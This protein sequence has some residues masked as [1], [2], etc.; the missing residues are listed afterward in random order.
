[1]QQQTLT[2][3]L[4]A[5][6]PERQRQAILKSLTDEEK[7]FLR[8]SWSF[9][10]RENQ[11]APGG[12][13]LTWLILAGRG[14]G[15]TRAGAEWIRGM[16]CGDTPLA[17]GKA[18]RVALVAETAADARDVMVE[19]ESGLLAIHPPDFRPTYEPSKRRLTWPNGAIGTIFN[20][21]EPDQLRGP[22]H[23]A[24]WS[25]ELAKW[26]YAQETWDNLQFGLRLGTNP[27]QV[28]TT[29]PRPIQAL[30]RIASDDTTV[31]TKGST[32][33]NAANLADSFIKKMEARYSGT[34]LGRQE[35]EAEILD[36]SPDALWRRA[37]IDDQ[38]I[39]QTSDGGFKKG[40][41]TVKLPDFKRVVVAV[42]PAAESGGSGDGESGAETGIIVAALGVDGRGYILDDATCAEGPDGW[43]R[44]AVAAYD[45]HEGDRIV[46]EKNQGG[47]MV[48][49]VIR[50]VRKTL[51]IVPVHA[52]RGKV[53]RAEPVAALYEQGRVS[54]VGTFSELE[55]QMVVFTP[56]GIEGG[57][58]GD[59]VD[60][61][62][63][64]LTDLFPSIISHTPPKNETKGREDRWD[65]AFKRREGSTSKWKTR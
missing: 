54:H 23:D 36:D 39:V 34:R 12:D 55:D 11:L 35:L 49:S 13:W 46:A 38:R 16:V 28:I 56:F 42:D 17:A 37:K 22:Q 21:T 6:L 5:S 41:E 40:G 57:T 63:W 51:P 4:L 43:A 33:D 26:R 19:G 50:S 15:K 29:T 1:M 32:Y 64:A 8:Y 44:R 30:K 10:A 62:V 2:A 45:L 58:T 60:A 3:E 9:W 24:A 27:Q 61:L 65:R 31:I 7:A 59:R 20:A 25:D 14:F 18:S 52:S 47:A 53:T 48:T